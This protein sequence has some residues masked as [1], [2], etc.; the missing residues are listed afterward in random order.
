MACL[1]QFRVPLTRIYQFDLS[2]YS[3]FAP[4]S[5]TRLPHQPVA[6][7]YLQILSRDSSWMIDDL[8]SKSGACPSMPALDAHQ[9]LSFPAVTSISSSSPSSVSVVRWQVEHFLGRHILS[10]QTHDLCKS[11]IDSLLFSPSKFII[12][13]P[14]FHAPKSV[15]DAISEANR[16]TGLEDG[17]GI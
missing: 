15:P 12:T 4:T 11:I 5:P 2:T 10:N 7:G 6:L 8:P 1:W 16:F 3:S 9:Y 17:G 14:T 13:S